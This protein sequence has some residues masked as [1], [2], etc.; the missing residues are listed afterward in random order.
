[1]LCVSLLFPIKSQW[2]FSY[3]YL[4]NKTEV[5]CDKIFFYYFWLCSVYKTGRLPFKKWFLSKMFLLNPII[6][7]KPIKIYNICCLF[8]SDNG[9][10]FFIFYFLVLC[11]HITHIKVKWNNICCCLRFCVGKFNTLLNR[12]NGIKGKTAAGIMY[13]S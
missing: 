3:F 13:I 6:Y 10:F 7:Q 1:M 2:F 12:E 4:N 8:T 11:S 9:I 5:F